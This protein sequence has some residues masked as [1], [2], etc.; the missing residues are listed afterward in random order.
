M[1][2]VGMT[3][4]QPIELLAKT[5]GNSVW[6]EVPHYMHNN[7]KKQ[8]KNVHKWRVAGTPIVPI[9]DKIL[10]FLLVKKKQALLCLELCKYI[11]PKGGGSNK[12]TPQERIIQESVRLP[13]F[14]K[15]YLLNHN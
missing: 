8:G 14:K 6:Y 11:K 13:L 10:P 1:I 2:E 15:M 9:L 4:K 3:D 7:I 5:F 12:W